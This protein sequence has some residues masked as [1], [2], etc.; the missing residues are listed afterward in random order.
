[1]DKQPRNREVTDINKI[2]EIL[3]QCKLCHIAMVDDDLPYVVQMRYGY[4]SRDENVLK[5]YSHSA[6][7]L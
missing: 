5:L 6:P 4:K 3:L 7:S 1:M 2:E